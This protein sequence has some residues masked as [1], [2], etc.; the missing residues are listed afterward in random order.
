MASDWKCQHCGAL[1]HDESTRKR[2]F[3]S[4]K[5][6]GLYSQASR[7]ASAN[8]DTYRRLYAKVAVSSADACWPW[9]GTTTKGYGKLRALGRDQYAHRIAWE[10]ANGEK[11]GSR[12]ACHHCDNPLCCNP[13]HIYA[14]TP[15]QNIEDM[16]RRGR[17]VSV[18][19]K[20]HLNPRAKLTEA[21]VAAI[22]S[23][24]GHKTYDALS[25]QFGVGANQIFK[26]L[27]GQAWS[28]TLA[29]GKDA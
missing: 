20:G 2:K 16:D 29:T 14:G 23:N 5:C 8:E 1:F 13:R 10:L 9:Q 26:I 18:P 19:M 11:L 15:K 24:A 17:R 21:D 22:R 28:H 4:L 27:S 7:L 3:C 6:V 12:F 25:K